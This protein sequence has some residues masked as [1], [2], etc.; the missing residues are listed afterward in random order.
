MCVSEEPQDVADVLVHAF[1]ADVLLRHNLFAACAFHR[2]SGLFA[3]QI[4]ERKSILVVRLHELAALAIKF[5]ESKRRLLALLRTSR[6]KDLD[7]RD[8][9]I[10]DRL[11]CSPWEGDG[12]PVVFD[13]LFGK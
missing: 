9:E 11:K 3:L 6:L 1:G 7:M 12:G 13:E 2:D 10:A 5:A 8:D 4:N